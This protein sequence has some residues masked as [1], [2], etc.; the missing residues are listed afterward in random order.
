M[1]INKFHQFFEKFNDTALLKLGHFLVESERR[2]MS[3]S[4]PIF[5]HFNHIRY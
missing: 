1:Q 3:K 2:K 4:F 5:P